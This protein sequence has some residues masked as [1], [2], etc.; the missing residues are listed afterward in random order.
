MIFGKWGKKVKKYVKEKEL[1]G[2][3]DEAVWKELRSSYVSETVWMEYI[4]HVAST[5]FT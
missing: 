3:N 5:R 1:L 2:W 4:Q